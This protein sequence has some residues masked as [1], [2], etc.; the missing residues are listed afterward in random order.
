M[1]SHRKLVFLTLCYPIPSNNASSSWSPKSIPLSPCPT[2]DYDKNLKVFPHVHH[3]LT[4]LKYQCSLVHSFYF[5]SC[6]HTDFLLICTV[7]FCAPKTYAETGMNTSI[8]CV[9]INKQF[10]INHLSTYDTHMRTQQISYIP[11]QT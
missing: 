7:G 9:I 8:H 2:T 11:L 3:Y 10:Q 4:C 5:K 1:S 6:L